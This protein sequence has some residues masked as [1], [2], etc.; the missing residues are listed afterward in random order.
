MTALY[1]SNECDEYQSYFTIAGV[2]VSVLS[3]FAMSASGIVI[4]LRYMMWGHLLA[5]LFSWLFHNLLK[6][7]P[8]GDERGEGSLGTVGGSDGGQFKSLA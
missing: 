8:K 6:L 1:R 2:A 5:L 7:M 4:V 3:G